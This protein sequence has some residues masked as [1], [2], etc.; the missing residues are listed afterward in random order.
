MSVETTRKDV[1]G[2]SKG[3]GASGSVR[4][5]RPSHFAR[6]IPD[7]Y[8]ET[9]R[10]GR[11]YGLEGFLRLDS[12]NSDDNLIKASDVVLKD[13]NGKVLSVAIDRIIE[14]GDCRFVKFNGYDS[15]ESAQPMAGSVLFV[16]REHARTL[17]EGE[18]YYGD[19]IG[20]SVVFESERIGEVTGLIEGAQSLILEVRKNDGKI[21]L[22]P[23][24]KVYVGEPDLVSRSIELLNGGLLL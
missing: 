8:I 16:G 4:S 7:G 14:K 11:T 1:S 22:V 5:S 20:L 10:I 2:S 13:R 6:T 18:T 23:Y 24:M 19:L 9:G 15:R 12:D 3:S 17:G 21:A